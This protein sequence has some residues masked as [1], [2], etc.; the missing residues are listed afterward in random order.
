MKSA[1]CLLLF[2]C[3]LMAGCRQ[4]DTLTSLTLDTTLL[5]EGD[6]I[7]R[8]G[9]SVS[10]RAVERAEKQNN[11][12]YSHIGVL[13]RQDSSWFVVHCVPGESEETGGEEV[14]KCDSLP[15]FLRSDR[16]EAGAVFRYDTLAEVRASIAADARRLL[17]RKVPF[18]RNYLCSD[19]SKL[20]CTEMVDLLY[21]HAGIDLT[22][23]RR[24][25]PP[26]FREPVIY[27]SD[28]TKNA[29]LMEIVKV[30]E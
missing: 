9:R 3:V 16:A 4:P 29:K 5:E 15:L 6:L 2:L 26:A 1:H 18:D 20:Y 19:T 23:G 7:L 22:E 17:Q 12:A 28:I 21:R 8:R 25:Q 13:V 11:S 27:P 10:S 24:H 14:I 30:K